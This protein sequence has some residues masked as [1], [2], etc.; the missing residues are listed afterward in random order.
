MAPAHTPGCA[1]FVEG[2]LQLSS[3]TSKGLL[4]NWAEVSLSKQ[5]GQKERTRRKSVGDAGL[6][7]NFW[8]RWVFVAALRLSLVAMCGGYSSLWC[9]GFSLRWPL[10][11][12]STGSRRAGFSS[13]GTWA[14]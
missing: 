5:C 2:R 9:M 11:L 8:L 10:L 14:Q 7:L 13:C 12:R 3:A 4:G 6:F 1:H